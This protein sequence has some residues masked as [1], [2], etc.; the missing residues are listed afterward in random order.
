M[1]RIWEFGVQV[2][3]NFIIIIIIIMDESIGMDG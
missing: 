3:N 2:W 1:E